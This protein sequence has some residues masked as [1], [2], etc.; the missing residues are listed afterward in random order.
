MSIFKANPFTFQVQ[1]IQ[2]HHNPSMHIG[3]NS[4]R[5]HATLIIPISFSSHANFHTKSIIYN[6]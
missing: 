2:T 5:Y 1:L 6:S 3:P 4:S